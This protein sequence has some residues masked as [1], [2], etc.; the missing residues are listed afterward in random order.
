[1]KSLAVCAVIVAMAEGCASQQGSNQ[2]SVAK[3]IE[4]QTLEALR[5][6]VQLPAPATQ[7]AGDAPPQALQLYAQGRDALLQNDKSKAAEKLAAALQIDPASAVCARDLGYAYLGVDNDRALAAFQQVLKYDPAN[8]DARLQEARIQI[9]AKRFD[10]AI[11]ELRLARLSDEYQ[12]GGGFAAVVDL[13]LGRLL[14][15]RQYRYAALQCYEG[16]IKILDAGDIDLR[17]R[18]ELSELIGKPAA[19]IL[20]TADLAL[21]CEEY[22]RAIEL[23]QRI[24][25]QEPQAAALLELRIARA[26]LAADREQDATRRAFAV[27]DT[28]RSARSV[29]DA[30]IDLFADRGGAPEALRQLNQLPVTPANQDTWHL[31][32]A[33]LLLT[34]NN[35]AD[36]ITEINRVK[37]F[38]LNA[39]RTTVHAYRAAG[40]MDALVQKLIERTATSPNHW[41]AISHGWTM[42][43]Q[44]G[45]PM[46]LSIAQIAA[47]HIPQNLSAAKAFVIS[48]LYGDSGQPVPA[49]RSLQVAM[50]DD[51]V[52]VRSI[53]ATPV[54]EVN[55][56]LDFA[57]STDLASLLTDL[58]DDPDLLSTSIATLLRQGQKQIVQ[59]SL[60]LANTQSPGNVV[61]AAMYAQ[62]LSADQQNTEAAAVL[63]RA[64]NAV[65]NSSQLYYLS[66]QYSA[67]GD[68][69]SSEAVLRKAYEK[70]PNSAAVCNDLGFML[71]DEGRDLGF[72]EKLLWK[73]VGIERDNPAYLDSL[74]WVLYKRS[75]FGQALQYLQQALND[76]DP[77]DPG[78]LDHAGDA[79]YRNK[80]TEEARAYW[81]QA[82]DAVRDR[83]ASDPQLRLKLEQKVRQ[84]DAKQVVDVAPVAK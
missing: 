82:I 75:N 49:Q 2:N 50:K 22:D 39:V 56:D 45:Q 34:T 16:V 35:A 44:L 26:E 64:V 61:L 67:M 69:K 55:A 46:P 52:F 1:M 66:S 18:P 84:L 24:E 72:A 21:A 60:Q 23:Y 54:A 53:A 37:T 76:S 79:A 10:D 48:Q 40:E 62:V 4:W 6:P 20:R 70:D 19:L 47:T 14:E 41:S 7:P 29:V 25:K 65:T 63:D 5:P 8:G 78:V 59:E 27:V 11:H 38:D 42:L 81:I 77:V 17:G 31:L 30:F 51:A 68:N 3:P 13:L 74:G 80:Q 71:A 28:Y 36:A 57:T 33:Q 58:S 73:A 43:T 32:R 9:D 12:D 83:G 15:S